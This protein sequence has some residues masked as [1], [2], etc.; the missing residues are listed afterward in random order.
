M[1]ETYSML[2]GLGLRLP[3][4]ERELDVASPPAFLR[5]IAGRIAEAVA[6]IEIF[7]GGDVN[8]AVETTIASH[9]HK[10][11]LVIAENP[12]AVPRLLAG[13]PGVRLAVAGDREAVVSFLRENR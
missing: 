12:A 4:A 9:R 7:T 2:A 13:L 6:V 8:G 5:Q 3:S 11:V 1:L 10:P